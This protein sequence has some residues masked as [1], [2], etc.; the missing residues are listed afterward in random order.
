MA[1]KGTIVGIIW[2]VAATGL[3]IGVA[4]ERRAQAKLDRANRALQE[5]LSQADGLSAENQRLSNLVAQ[6][7]GA[8]SRTA[9]RSEGPS[10]TDERAKELERLRGEVEA[11]RQQGKEAEAL[12]EDTRR[13][14]AARDNGVRA[15]NAAGV[16]KAGNVAM[17]NGSP[18]EIVRAEYGTE[19]T[20][21]DVAAELS[22]RIRGDGLK[23]MASNN[24][25]GDPDFGHVKHLVVVYRFGGVM[26]TNEFREGDVVMLP[27]D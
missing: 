22:E 7:N 27:G 18:F 2:V 5:Q 25:K 19:T 21:M 26:R 1:A 16:A 8:P 3:A 11:L 20:N 9:E 10:A 23:A 24:L 4:V 17:V 13:I 15:P 14:R 6:A 12:R